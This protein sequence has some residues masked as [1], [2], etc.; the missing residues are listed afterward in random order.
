MFK[1]TFKKNL[2]T[3]Q[4][5]LLCTCPPGLFVI[6]LFNSIWSNHFH[7]YLCSN[8]TLFQAISRKITIPSNCP[9]HPDL[10]VYVRPP[11]SVQVY[12][13]NQTIEDEFLYVPTIKPNSNQ[14]LTVSPLGFLLSNSSP[15][16]IFLIKWVFMS[17]YHRPNSLTKE[18]LARKCAS[19]FSSA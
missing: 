17:T 14:H 4:P 3:K 9:N 12:Y 10:N 13:C 11:K 1:S 2:Y 16:C 8:S 6:L 19:P 18:E 7:F 5:M 15:S